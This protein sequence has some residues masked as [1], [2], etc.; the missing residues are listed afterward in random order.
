MSFIRVFN[1][2]ILSDLGVPGTQGHQEFSDMGLTILRDAHFR[3]GEFKLL[4][5]P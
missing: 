1:E 5:G 3:S 4:V 2:Y